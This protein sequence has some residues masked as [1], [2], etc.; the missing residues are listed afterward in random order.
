MGG[1]ICCCKMFFPLLLLLFSSALAA[2]HPDAPPGLRGSPASCASLVDTRP[3]RI[4][5]PHILSTDELTTPKPEP[6]TEGSAY[7]QQLAYCWRMSWFYCTPYGIYWDSA[8][9][10]HPLCRCKKGVLAECQKY[11]SGFSC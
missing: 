10:Y 3:A 5:Q 1:T 6:C 8:C 2:W 7:K 11:Y 9:C 4:E